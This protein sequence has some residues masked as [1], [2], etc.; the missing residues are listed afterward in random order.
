VTQKRLEIAKLVRRIH[1]GQQPLAAE[2][3]E[4]FTLDNVDLQVFKQLQHLQAPLSQTPDHR[5]M[6]RAAVDRAQRMIAAFGPWHDNVGRIVQGDETLEKTGRDER[7]VTRDDDHPIVVSRGQR[8]VEAAERP[9]F[10]HAIGNAA[11]PAGGVERTVAN[12]Q[13]VIGKLAQFIELT[14]ENSS[15]ADDQRTFLAPAEAARAAAV[16]NRG[17]H[18]SLAILPPA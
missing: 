14:V 17:A 10:G 16:K 8:G 6:T 7:H 18:H 9:A 3:R 15:S 5:R 12:Q 4:L 1:I 2:T 13:D 11:K